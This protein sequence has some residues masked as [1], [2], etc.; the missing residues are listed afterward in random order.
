MRIARS[1]RRLCLQKAH[2][3]GVLLLS[4]GDEVADLQPVD[5]ADLG[6][7]L[8]DPQ[9]VVAEEESNCDTI[10]ASGH[11]VEVRR[12][13][14]LEFLPELLDVVLVLG[15]RENARQAGLVDLVGLVP[16]DVELSEH[17]AQLRV[18]LGLAELVQPV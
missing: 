5:P 3:V 2:H 18:V 14:L 10:G 16:R 13:R 12:V 11:D 7:F 9:Q 1:E 8:L 15:A 6:E 4:H 17:L